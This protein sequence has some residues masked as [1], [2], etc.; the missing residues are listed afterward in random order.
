MSRTNGAAMPG[1]AQY[2]SPPPAK[3]QCLIILAPWP[4]SHPLVMKTANS[5]SLTALAL[6]A[7]LCACATTPPSYDMVIL[8]GNIVDGSGSPAYVSADIAIDGD[9]IVKIGHL[10]ESTATRVIDAAGLTVVAG[11][12]R[13]PH[14]RGPQYQGQPR[15]R[16]LPAPGCRRLLGGNCG[17]RGRRSG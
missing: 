2:S 6:S 11:F 13:P 14:P 3:G 15:G 1:I 7:T 16:E 12:Y 5:N 17:Q 9:R 4:A 8:D 10:D